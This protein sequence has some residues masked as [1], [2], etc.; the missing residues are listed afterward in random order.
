M[1]DFDLKARDWDK[2]KV[3]M[4]RT[5][6]VADKLLNYIPLTKE[7]KAMEFGAGTG[8]LSFYL[9]EYF[10]EITLMDNSIEML[11][12][13]EQKMEKNDRLKLKTLHFDLESS[14]YQGVRYDVIYSQMVL[15]HIKDI[16]SIFDKFYKLLNTGGV[17]AIADLYEEDGSFHDFDPDVHTGFD[18]EKLKL[19]AMKSGFKNYHAEPCFVIRREDAEGRPQEY[20]LFLLTVNK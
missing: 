5:M 18:P 19:M 9:K 7:L 14:E 1:N 8:L 6:A 15:H 2:N 17:L 10:S 3:N 13:A 16:E 11:K 4:E 20:P 12:A